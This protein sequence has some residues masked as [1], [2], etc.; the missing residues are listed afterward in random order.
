MG[1]TVRG[2][3]QVKKSF[4]YD[5]RNNSMIECGKGMVRQ[6]E[7]THE[8]RETGI[9]RAVSGQPV[10]DGFDAQEGEVGLSHNHGSTFIVIGEKGDCMDT[11]AV[12][13][14]KQWE[15]AESSLDN[16]CFLRK[17]KQDPHLSTRMWEKIVC[18]SL[19]ERGEDIKSLHE[20][21]EGMDE[22]NRA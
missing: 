2:K 9:T 8:T 1:T 11:N 14:L 20:Q 10:K 13:W 3:S 17:R 7:K 19:E 18:W 15:P 5:E 16:F 21:G 6:R 4:H 22:R 12:M